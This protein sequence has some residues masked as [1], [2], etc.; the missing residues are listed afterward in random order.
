MKNRV[1]MFYLIRNTINWLF[2]RR[3]DK[4]TIVFINVFM[5]IWNTWINSP[6]YCCF[7]EE[8]T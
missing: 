6:F 4:D 7:C 2:N 1:F 5:G 8:T 3:H